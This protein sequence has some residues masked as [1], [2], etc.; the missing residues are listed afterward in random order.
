M[1]DQERWLRRYRPAGPGAPR[2]VCFP[3]AGGAANYFLP[4]ADALAPGV[5]VAA[6]QYPGRQDRRAEPG[7]D[8]IGVLADRLHAVLSDADSRPLTLFGHSMG[9]VVAYEVARRLRRDD[10]G[11][12]LHLFASGRRA[13]HRVRPATVH[14][15]GDAGIIAEVRSLGG[16][17]ASLLADPEV[18]EMVL[19]AL[20]ADYRAIELYR[21]EPGGPPPCPITVLTGDRD[22]QTTLDEAHDWR[23]HSR[24]PFA[25]HVFAG[26]H[27][28][29]ADQ[30]TG[31]LATLR[32]H[33]G[34]R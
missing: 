3:H 22:P 21:W 27:F 6:V 19:P 29:L 14:T 10:P 34:S 8:D 2:L 12:A 23:R 5:D 25:V 26:G 20:R 30:A 24:D 9:A 33:F 32:E 11:R 4:V 17:H 7:I 28:F 13:P 18:L 16:T 31:V 15:G 1:T